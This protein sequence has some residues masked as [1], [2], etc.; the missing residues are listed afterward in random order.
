MRPELFKIPGINF[1]VPSFGAMVMIGFLGAVWWM[2][3]RASRVKQNPDLVLNFA[4]I[5]LICSTLGARTFYVIHYWDSQFKHQPSE[6]LHLSAGGFEF[7]GG[8]V[9]ALIPCMLYAVWKR[10]SLRLWLDLVTPSLLFGMG[11]G[12]VGC[13]LY[14]CCWGTMCSTALP[15]AVQ[16]PFGSPPQQYQW[17]SRQM[18]LPAE[19]I[20]VDKTGVALPLPRPVIEKGFDVVE[21][22]VGEVN[23][24]VQAART[25]G[26]SEKLAQAEQIQRRLQRGL[27]PLREYREAFPLST[28]ELQATAARPDLMSRHVHPAQLYSAAGP[29]LLAW[30]TNVYFYR[31]KRHGTVF[32]MGMML[33]ALERFVEEYLRSDNPL[34][35]MGLT[36]SQAVSIG[37][38]A[39]IGLWLLMLMRMPL[40]S[41]LAV[42]WV[43]P[44][45]PKKAGLEPKLA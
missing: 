21:K 26:D 25:S 18:V 12:R 11:V 15:W 3:R 22:K 31:R 44:P 6:I 8:L 34:D 36:V 35:T 16:F 23:A 19:L 13:Y 5:A 38:L 28:A 1:I 43:P 10:L 27:A 40:R 32:A 20:M 17:E 45:D 37:L 42:P 33:Y 9:G 7:Y 29:L 2:T 24:A 39:V 41:P 14:G 4:F 30:L